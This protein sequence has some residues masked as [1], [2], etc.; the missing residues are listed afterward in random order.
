MAITSTT[1]GGILTALA[2]RLSTVSGLTV[3]DYEPRDLAVPAA[4]IILETAERSP[5][6]LGEVRRESQIGS[7]DLAC[8]WTVRVWSSGDYTRASDARALQLVG[9][10]IAA[11]DADETLGGVVLSASAA[12]A[13]RERVESPPES[14][15]EFVTYIVTVTTSSL[16]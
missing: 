4:T 5:V 6:E 9:Q 11:I 15:N 13:T 12:T 8:A 3:Y 2:T 1:L 7:V 10:V 16:H 14:G